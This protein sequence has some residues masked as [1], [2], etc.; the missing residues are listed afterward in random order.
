MSTLFDK[1]K[2]RWPKPFTSAIF[3]DESSQDEHFF[4]LGALYFW[5]KTE[6]YK[7]QIAKFESELA[8][9][10]AK[11][12][13]SVIKWQDVPK[14]SLKLKGY[15]ACIEYLASQI[16]NHSA[17]SC[18]VSGLLKGD[19]PERRSIGGGLRFK[20]MVV[21]TTKYRLKNK[22]TGAFDKLI[23]YLKFY[24]LHLADGIMLTQRG[25]FY[26][27]TIDDYE[28]RPATR[29][30]A[31]ALGKAVEGRYL[32]QFQPEDKTI[33]KYK[34]QH[35][36]LKCVDD[37]DSNLI[38]MADLLT[39]AVAF[40]RNGGLLRSSGV[41]VGRAELV[42]LIQKSY[43]GVRLDQARAFG[44]FDIWEF[45]VPGTVGKSLT[46]RGEVPY[47]P[48]IRS[49]GIRSRTKRIGGDFLLLLATTLGRFG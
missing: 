7:N 10:K 23:G 8:E 4:V 38:Q 3:S 44:P 46:R 41:S 13:I 34:F 42:G 15:K 26:D 6:D 21:D 49:R 27:I 35:S 24:T 31:V 33:D 16:K 5:W 19:V 9:I 43:R 14:A 17:P 2:L 29:H 32:E 39:G 11:H 36:V 20:C 22:A 48:F 12:G 25:Y 18:A 47:L 30:D 40:V 1:S 28:W 37:K 45:K